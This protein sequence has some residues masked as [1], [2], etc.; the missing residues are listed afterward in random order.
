MSGS[1]A[2]AEVL[3]GFPFGEAEWGELEVLAT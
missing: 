3:I 2:F 1:Q